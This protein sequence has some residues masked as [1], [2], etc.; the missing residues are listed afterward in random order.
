VM[1]RLV[2]ECCFS[3]LA[4]G[5]VAVDAQHRPRVSL[6]VDLERPAAGHHDGRAIVAGVD[7]LALPAA[8]VD[9]LGVYF[10][11]RQRK[12]RL[13]NRLGGATQD[14]G[15]VPAITLFGATVPDA[16]GPR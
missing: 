16:D 2:L 6:R 12:S 14:I 1:Q 7:E 5:D 15:V 11:E 13:Q 10:R 4:A 3:M 8:S 9:E